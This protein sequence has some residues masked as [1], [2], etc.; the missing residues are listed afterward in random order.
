MSRRAVIKRAK[1]ARSRR[2]RDE[3]DPI[4]W[5]FECHAEF[6]KSEC[7]GY[8]DVCPRCAHDLW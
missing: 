1:I 8:E 3:K 2:L 6:R 7:E 5:C 4:W